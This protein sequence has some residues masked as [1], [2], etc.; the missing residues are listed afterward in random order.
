M[1]KRKYLPAADDKKIIWLLNFENKLP[2]YATKYGITPGE[3]ANVTA[4]KNYAS[5]WWQYHVQLQTH[6]QGVTAFKNALF[7]G[8]AAGADI[9]VEPV[10]PTTGP[11]PTATEPDVFGRATSI[12]NRIKQHNKYSTADGEALGLEGA[13]Q[14]GPDVVNGKPVLTIKLIGGVP[15]IVWSKGKFEGI[16]IQVRRAGGAWAFLALDTHPDYDDTAPLPAT[17]ETWE[18]KAI[19][20]FENTRVGLW[21][22]VVAARVK[23]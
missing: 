8:V 4:D 23:A 14:E 12:G 13:E 17:E 7:N 15:R 16:E 9:P 10:P 5:Y 11:V 20:H 2:T 18:Y 19:Y 6:A 21:S 22:E 3:V 1:A